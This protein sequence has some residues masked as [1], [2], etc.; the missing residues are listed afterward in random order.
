MPLTLRQFAEQ[1]QQVLDAATPAAFPKLF[2]TLRMDLK[3][4]FLGRKHLSTIHGADIF[5]NIIAALDGAEWEEEGELGRNF[6]D[7]IKN[8]C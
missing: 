7:L 8:N 1:S 6:R 2:C 4:L 3:S 5:K